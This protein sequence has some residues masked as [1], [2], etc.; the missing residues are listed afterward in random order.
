[1]QR[2]LFFFGTNELAKG[3]KFLWRKKTL[4]WPYLDNK[5]GLWSWYLKYIARFYFIFFLLSSSL[6]CSQIW[7][8]PPLVNIANVGGYI[9]KLKKKLG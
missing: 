1:M 9:T 7:L 8:N 6:T 3:A 2:N 4:K 5:F